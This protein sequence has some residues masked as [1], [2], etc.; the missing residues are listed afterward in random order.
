MT[1]I[2]KKPIRNHVFHHVEWMRR[3]LVYDI[4]SLSLG[5]CCEHSSE[6]KTT[7][8]SCG[9][10]VKKERPLLMLSPYNINV[11]FRGLNIG[12]RPE[13]GLIHGSHPI[14]IHSTQRNR[15]LWMESRQE[16]WMKTR[17][18][19]MKVDFRAKVGPCLLCLFPTPSF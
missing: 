11:G 17:K 8:D 3:M 2:G 13:V 9:R 19:W 15:Y 16:R 1:R 12:R 10:N 14:H 18:S 7:R 5:R 6:L 4:P